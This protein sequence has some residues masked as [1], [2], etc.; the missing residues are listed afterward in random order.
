MIVGGREGCVCMCIITRSNFLCLVLIL[1]CGR[2][3]NYYLTGVTSMFYLS[4]TLKVDTQTVTLMPSTHVQRELRSFVK[5]T[6]PI[7]VLG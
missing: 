7:L 1:L 5:C 4:L 2:V 3:L 6:D